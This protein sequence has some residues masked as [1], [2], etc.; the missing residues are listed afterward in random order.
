M[1]GP[2]REDE[3]LR[4]VSFFASNYNCCEMFYKMKKG[5]ECKENEVELNTKASRLYES[6]KTLNKLSREEIQ[7]S[8]DDGINVGTSYIT[9]T[10]ELVLR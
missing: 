5:I 6:L 2:V 8:V 7:K 9:K 10:Q 4:S 3:Q 1:D